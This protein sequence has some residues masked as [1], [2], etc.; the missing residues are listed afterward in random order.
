MKAL[1]YIIVTLALAIGFSAPSASAQDAVRKDRPGHGQHGGARMENPLL[2]G[3]EL[4]AEQQAQIKAIQEESMKQM[5]GLSPEERRSKGREMRQQNSKKIREVLTADQQKV[6]DEN[7]K[8]MPQRGGG[9]D[10]KGPGKEGKGGK[11]GGKGGDK[12]GG[13]PPVE[14]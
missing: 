5:Q 4:T 10:G 14:E 6:F 7:L 9:K 12:G 11:G 8:N 13:K 3:I 2:K 1:K